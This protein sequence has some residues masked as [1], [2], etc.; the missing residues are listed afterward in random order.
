M[1]RCRTSFQ[2]STVSWAEWSAPKPVEKNLLYESRSLKG[3][4]PTEIKECWDAV[5]LWDSRTNHLVLCTNYKLC[6]VHTY[7]HPHAHSYRRF[8]CK[9]STPNR[10]EIR[11]LKK[12]YSL[13]WFLR[14]FALKIQATYVQSLSL[15]IHSLVCNI[16]YLT[17]TSTWKDDV[18]CSMPLLCFGLFLTLRGSNTLFFTDIINPFT[19]VDAV[20]SN[21][22]L[23]VE[24][25]KKRCFLF[26]FPTVCCQL[27]DTMYINMDMMKV[28]EEVFLTHHAGDL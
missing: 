17:N 12:G 16:S 19:E 24:G 15:N 4:T 9:P 6:A 14:C 1:N 27:W 13:N 22:N 26:F 18:I 25:K 2:V 10:S 28:G 20:L 21:S 8:N 23:T 3:L 7:A 11:R 5:Y